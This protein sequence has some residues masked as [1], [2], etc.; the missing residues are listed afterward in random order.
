[1]TNFPEDLG[2]EL[3]PDADVAALTPIAGRTAAEYANT[4]SA[5]QFQE[6]LEE[7]QELVALRAELI[8]ATDALGIHQEME[9]AAKP[10]EGI[11]DLA[12]R[13]EQRYVLFASI[14]ERARQRDPEGVE[15]YERSVQAVAL[16]A[17][18]RGFELPFI[19]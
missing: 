3:I 4:R 5:Q 2:A 17:K 16:A 11:P 12:E 15:R 19:A 6:M 13:Y 7:D 18:A 10:L 1:M 8:H 9:G 14:F